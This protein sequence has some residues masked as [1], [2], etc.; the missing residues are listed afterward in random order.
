M[1]KEGAA[2]ASMRY[3]SLMS[4]SMTYPARKQPT[5]EPMELTMMMKE[6][7]P[8]LTPMRSFRSSRVGPIT[9]STIPR[10][11]SNKNHQLW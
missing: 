6:M 11:G 9:P 5:M 10:T 2:P 1:K 8:R 4:L 3:W 7:L